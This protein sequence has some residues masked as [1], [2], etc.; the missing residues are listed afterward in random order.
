MK[1]G[2]YF[3]GFTLIEVI[4]AMAVIAIALAA[5]LKTVSNVVRNTASLHERIVASWVA[6][7]VMHEHQLSLNGY[8][9]GQGQTDIMQM[10][11]LWS[12]HVYDTTD[13]NIHKI[14]IEVTKKDSNSDFVFS[15]ISFFAANYDGSADIE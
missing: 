8:E 4:V 1:I 12:K 11:W 9:H 2:N 15:H 7:N 3:Y 13:E 10:S 6:E 14:E 5:T